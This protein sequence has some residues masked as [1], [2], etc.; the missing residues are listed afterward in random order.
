MF[1]TIRS[2]KRLVASPHSIVHWNLSALP[3]PV[4][5]SGV[6]ELV[7]ALVGT[8]LFTSCDLH[9][10]LQDLPCTAVLLGPVYSIYQLRLSLDSSHVLLPYSCLSFPVCFGI[11]LS[12]VRCPCSSSLTHE[13][14]QTHTHL[15]TSLPPFLPLSRNLVLRAKM[16]DL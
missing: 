5:S 14:T 12:K 15:P 16:L 9:G 10:A 11:V 13:H 8:L 7:H 4:Q 1:V 3:S 6:I 2:K